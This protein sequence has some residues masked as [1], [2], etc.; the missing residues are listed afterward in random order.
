MDKRLFDIITNLQKS[1][2]LKSEFSGEGLSYKIREDNFLYIAEAQKLRFDKGIL[3]KARLKK[4]NTNIPK[5]KKLKLTLNYP[6]LI[7][8]NPSIV[9]SVSTGLYYNDY[10]N[11]MGKSNLIHHEGYSF[12]LFNNAKFKNINLLLNFIIDIFKPIQD[13]INKIYKMY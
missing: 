12:E 11:F 3:G 2:D 7:K 4:Y 1:E 5:D 6:F 8:I 9:W 10:F 13:D